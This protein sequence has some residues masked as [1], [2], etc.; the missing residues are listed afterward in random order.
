MGKASAS[1]KATPAKPTKKGSSAKASAVK[2]GK[3]GATEKSSGLSERKLAAIKEHDE[4]S[5]LE[6]KMKLLMKAEDDDEF[7]RVFDG[8]TANESQTIWKKFEK[9]RLAQG[10]NQQYDMSTRGTG[11]RSKK[12]ALLKAFL[13]DG[14]TT[15]GK[16]YRTCIS[17]VSV[18]NSSGYDSTWSP[19]QAMIT[20]YGAQEL[21]ARVAAGTIK[22]RKNPK[23]RWGDRGRYRREEGE[24]ERLSERER[25]RERERESAR[26]QG[27]IFEALV[28]GPKPL[29]RAS[30]SRPLFRA[31]IEPLLRPLVEAL[32]QGP[33]ER[34]IEER[35][36][37]REREI[38][39]EGMRER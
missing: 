4:E 3:K 34:D 29:L 36:G 5:T 6:F 39:R 23:D 33:R 7:K 11:A 18:E 15:K 37:D 19:L 35:G 16:C 31:F 24:S 1:A 10:A 9:C 17:E 13:K 28:Q 21:K 8:L 20:K 30:A 25:E 22:C 27:L 2:P 32:A 38:R 12:L 26:A 14:M